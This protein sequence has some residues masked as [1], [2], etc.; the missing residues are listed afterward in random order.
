MRPKPISVFLYAASGSTSSGK[1][2]SRPFL[3]L[4]SPASGNSNPGSA[5]A[6]RRPQASIGSR[7]A[8]PLHSQLALASRDRLSSRGP[9]L[10]RE[11]SPPI[12]SSLLPRASQGVPE[13]AWDR[14]PSCLLCERPDANEPLNSARRQLPPP[15][16]DSSCPSSVKTSPSAFALPIFPLFLL[17]S[18][19]NYNINL[20]S[21]PFY[22]RNSI[23]GTL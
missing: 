11:E 20:S 4:A 15:L 10:L 19:L 12:A 21:Y 13:P 18:Y 23:V 3:A 9:K 17:V 5:S 6:S 2:P 14:A 7:N 8:S 22:S 16:A 1:S